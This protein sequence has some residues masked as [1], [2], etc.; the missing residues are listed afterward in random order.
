[1]AVN[2]MVGLARSRS[3]LLSLLASATIFGLGAVLGYSALAG[4]ELSP[5]T[6]AP[7]SG[8]GQAFW[9]ILGRNIPSAMLLYAG[10]VSFGVVSLIGITMLAAYVGATL[11]VVTSNSG[12]SGFMTETGAYVGFEFLGFILAGAAGLYP[13]AVA[14]ARGSRQENTGML[15]RYVHAMADSLRIFLVGV[16]VIV[17]AAC[18]EAIVMAAR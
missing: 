10:A 15:R 16:S 17:G 8:F 3:V 14:M 9:E 6:V 2:A 18:I 1:M 13:A 12:W 5:R 7:E 4:A 11:A